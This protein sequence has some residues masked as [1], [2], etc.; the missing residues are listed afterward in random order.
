MRA[1][2]FEF[3]RYA[4]V[5]NSGD[6]DRLCE[7]F[8]HPDAVMMTETRRIEGRDAL[9]QFLRWAHDG[10]RETMAPQRYAR[11]RD[12]VLAEVHITWTAAKDRPD[13]S[14]QKL[15]AGDAI[16]ARF[17]AVYELQDERIRLLKTCRWPV[18]WGL[19]E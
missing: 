6:D 10:V 14:I 4:E 11:D 15:K 18:G 13:F 12:T 2:R 9:L 3:S 5:F 16:T 7:E 1:P 8:Y 19:G 17:C